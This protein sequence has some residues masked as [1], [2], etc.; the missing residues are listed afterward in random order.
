[1]IGVIKTLGARNN[2]LMPSEAT[3]SRAPQPRLEQ[4]NLLMTATDQQ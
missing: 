3:P 1:M 2:F 4:M